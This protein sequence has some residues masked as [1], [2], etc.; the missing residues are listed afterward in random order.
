MWRIH[1][2]TGSLAHNFQLLHGVRTLQ[3]SRNQHRRVAL[4]AQVHGQLASKRRLTCPLQPSQH[5]DCGAS[6]GALKRTSSPS[7]DRHQLIVNNLHN[8]L[9]RVK[10]PRDLSGQRTFTH[11]PGKVTNHTH[12][13]IRIQQ[14]TTNLADRSI[15]IRLTEAS[16]APQVLKS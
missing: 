13:D 12:R 7:K 9:G 5:D 10:S 16:F 11:C 2:H 6:F 3:V 8:L 15:D 4:L 1:G 14:S